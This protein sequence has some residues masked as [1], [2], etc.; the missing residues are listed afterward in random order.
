MQQGAQPFTCGLVKLRLHRFR[1]GRLLLEAIQPLLLK[2][3]D[4]MAHRLGGTAQVAGDCFGALLSARCEQ[5]LA[6]M[7]G[8]GIR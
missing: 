5:N 7:Q 1:T 8:K 2:G 3:M 6:S 4:R